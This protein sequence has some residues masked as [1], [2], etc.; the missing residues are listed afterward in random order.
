VAATSHG[1]FQTGSPV[2]NAFVRYRDLA[3]GMP[4]QGFARYRDASAS[5]PYLYSA[6]K[7]SSSRMKIRNRSR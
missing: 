4:G 2:P 7:S 6:V 5:V 3:A 1:L